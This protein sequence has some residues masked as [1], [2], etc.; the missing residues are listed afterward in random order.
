MA[1]RLTIIANT[2]CEI[3]IDTEYYGTTKSGDESSFL[4]DEGIYWIQCISCINKCSS[5][6]DHRTNNQDAIYKII[7]SYDNISPYND[8][9]SIVKL[10]GQYGI[11]TNQNIEVIPIKFQRIMAINSSYAIVVL[12]G[13]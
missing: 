10:N 8:Q 12:N 11:V 9:L 4:L 5:A 1:S 6:F 2:D 3:Y 13:S 7:L